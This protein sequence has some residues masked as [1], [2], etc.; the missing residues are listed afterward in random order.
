L[1]YYGIR[2]FSILGIGYP[3]AHRALFHKVAPYSATVFD[4]D[5]AGLKSTL[6]W[7]RLGV[8]GCVWGVEADSIH[9]RN[10]KKILE[11]MTL[12]LPDFIPHVQQEALY[13]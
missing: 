10:V 9:L 5:R 11:N 4:Q 3:K 6:K 8:K 2:A 13:G 1:R 12:R 7:A